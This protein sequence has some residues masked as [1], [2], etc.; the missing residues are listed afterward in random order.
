MTH[1]WQ[2]VAGGRVV[3]TRG[4]FLRRLTGL[5]LLVPTLLSACTT[6]SPQAAPTSPP[7]APPTPPPAAPTTPPT[8]AA[9]AV[10][11]VVPKPAPTASAASQV[12]V[13]GVVLPTYV[14]AQGPKPDLPSTG[15][16]VDDAYL[17][18]PKTTLYKAVQQPP[19]RGGDVNV[20]S[21][22]FYPPFTPLEQ[23]PCCRRSIASSTRRCG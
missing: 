1:R 12:V 17:S 22:S 16:G 18:F 13:S 3:L 5:A 20:L 8:V 11:A 23:N 21:L 15:P 10:S 7:V 9:T 6:A 19:G 2:P 14:A 4:A